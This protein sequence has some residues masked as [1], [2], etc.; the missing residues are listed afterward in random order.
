VYKYLRFA[1]LV[2]KCY[3]WAK[4][5]IL[6]QLMARGALFINIPDGPKAKASLVPY[7]PENENINDS[8]NWPRS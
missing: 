3:C 4:V 1:Y 2:A 8:H 7:V 6:T 5:R